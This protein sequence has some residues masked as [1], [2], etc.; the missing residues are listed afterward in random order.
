MESNPVMKGYSTVHHTATSF[1]L[2]LRWLQAIL[3][4][5]ILVLLAATF[6]LPFVWMAS[7]SLKETYELF[8]FPPQ[9]IPPH[10]TLANYWFMFQRTEMI[11]WF[12]NSLLVAA[13]VTG[14]SLVFNSMAG[15]AF[16]KRKFVGR[17]VLFVLVLGTLMVPPHVTMIPV[18]IILS[19]IG[20]VNTYW[21]LILPLCASPFGIFL[22]RQ[23]MDTIPNDLLEAADMDGASEFQKYWRI[24]IPL[25][26]PALAT[27]TIFVFMG[28]WNNFLWPLIVTTES[29][30]RT[31]PV[32]IALF[33]GQYLTQ[34]G[35]VMA[36]ATIMFVPV[37][38][39][40]LFLQRYFVAGIAMTGLKA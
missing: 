38:I 19:K 17:N 29:M 13:A 18:Y 39:L 7:T 25:I 4:Y 5:S 32:G 22:C 21:A 15:Y 12:G 9:F 8:T 33:Q 14:F 30:M 37:L 34:W 11:R 27:L 2:V 26:K 20:L 16:S 35:Q 1:S 3:L 36:G 24:V 28:S 10:P 23:Y 31:L 40:F 6:L